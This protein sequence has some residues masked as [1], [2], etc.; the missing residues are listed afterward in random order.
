MKLKQTLVV[1]DLETTGTW[2]EKDRIV[3]IALVKC[4][5]EG[6]RETY[7]KRV[8]PGMPIPEAVSEIIG[9][10]NDDVK[11]APSFRL[12]AQ[13]VVDFLEGCDLA[14]FN[15]ERFDLPLLERELSQVGIEFRWQGRK[16]YDAQKVYHLNERRDL[17]A[18]YQFYCGKDLRNAHS[19]LADAEATLEILESQVQRYGEGA[20]DLET[21]SRFNYRSSNDFYDSTRKFRWWNGELYPMFGKYAKRSSLQEIC[22]R[23]PAYLQ[24]VSGADFSDEVKDL[25]T[26][27]LNG[28]FPQQSA[29]E[30]S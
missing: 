1:L 2:I 17:T 14:G 6:G 27:A 3:E 25:V 12:V 5:P 28:K 29:G 26:S 4:L 10:T 30:A 21:L 9:I 20:E 7:L 11:D 8:N 18:A 16:I 23:D 19:A 15:L 22:R 24:W 13:E